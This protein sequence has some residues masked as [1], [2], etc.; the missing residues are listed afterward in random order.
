MCIEDIRIRIEGVRMRIPIEDVNDA[1]RGCQ[2][3]YRRY[4]HF[5]LYETLNCLLH[6]ETKLTFMP[7]LQ[8]M[9]YFLLFSSYAGAV[10][11]QLFC[12]AAL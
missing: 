11:Q 9:Y 6:K 10:A 2:S 7:S 8:P 3:A 1:C 5:P 4:I 12:F